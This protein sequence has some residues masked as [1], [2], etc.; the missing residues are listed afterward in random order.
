MA[1]RF[2][3]FG[4][5]MLRLSP[6]GREVIGQSPRFD[7]WTAGAEANVA[8]ALARLGHQTAMVTAL[9][10]TALGDAALTTLKGHGVDCSGVRRLPGRMGL[11][12]VVTGSGVRPSHVVYDRAGSAFA[13]ASPESWEWDQLLVGADRLHLSGITPALGSGGTAAA[14]AAA[15]AATRLGVPLSFDGNYRS[16]LWGAWDGRPAATLAELVGQADILFGDER[17][18]EMMLGSTF[19]GDGDPRRRAAADAAFDAF[20]KLRTVA[21]LQRLVETSDRHRLRAHVLSR[22]K[23]YATEEI[24]LSGIVDRVG[25]GDAFAAGVLHGMRTGA[26][27]RNSAELGLRLA[28]W[29]HTIPGDMAPVTASDLNAVSGQGLDIAR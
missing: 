5:V 15:T 29:K 23:T 3:A 22:E 17:D 24:T 6:P 12:F 19:A 26:G 10:P 2:V 25:T 1:G 8:V 14:F 13:E 9:P 21:S 18:V 11:Y 28:A 16:Q 20:P 7:V 27:L 4:E